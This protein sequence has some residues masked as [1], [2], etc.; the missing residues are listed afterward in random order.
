M[1]LVEVDAGDSLV[2]TVPELDADVQYEFMVKAYNVVG[3]G[4][5]SV[6]SGPIWTLGRPTEVPAAPVL[7]G[8]GST[9]TTTTM[10]CQW[11]APALGEHDGP[12]TSYRVV[13]E[14]KDPL[15]GVQPLTFDV[16]NVL[17]CVCV[18]VCVC[19]CGCV[20]VCVCGCVPVCV[21]AG[22]SL[23]CP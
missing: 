13:V 18:C 23:N 14:P 11:T 17:R 7:G 21:P 15:S 8:D 6:S 20:P 19:V 3:H 10:E 22:G 4:P 9:T 5:F 1:G 12:V 16:D 2:F